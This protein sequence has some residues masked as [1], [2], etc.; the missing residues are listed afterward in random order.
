[1]KWFNLFLIF[2]LLALMGSMGA[3]AEPLP[4]PGPGP[5]PKGRPHTTRRPRN[6]KDDNDRR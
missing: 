3:T 4:Q 1:M 6:D 2:G 5:E